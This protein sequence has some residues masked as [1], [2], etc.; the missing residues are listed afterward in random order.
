MPPSSCHVLVIDDH[1]G[2]GETLQT[3]LEAVGCRVAVAE[4][5]YAGIAY[6]DAA[7]YDL[8]LVDFRMPGM[9][10]LEALDLLR[11]RGHRCLLM[12]TAFADEVTLAQVR[13]VGAEGILRKPIDVDRLLEIVDYVARHAG[14]GQVALPQSML[15]CVF[16]PTVR[17]AP[18]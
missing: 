18:C 4:T 17:L 1:P 8:V 9:N 11:R 10:G 5:P 6:S 13:E 15:E 16:A 7:R 2:F 3:I 12:V 14:A